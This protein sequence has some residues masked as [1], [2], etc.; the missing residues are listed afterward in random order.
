MKNKTI[1]LPTIILTI[2]FTALFF[3]RTSPQL[4]PNIIHAQSAYTCGGSGNV[5]SVFSGG[6]I[7][8]A[9]NKAKSGDTIKLSSGTYNTTRLKS[10]TDNITICS[11]TKHAAVI[12]NDAFSESILIDSDNVTIRGITFTSK[13]SR[14]AGGSV[15]MIRFD[16]SSGGIIEDNIIEKAST[17]QISVGGS[18]PG[19]RINNVT[20]RNNHL[21]DS[22]L[23]K[24]EGE[25][26]YIGSVQD[27]QVGTV[28]NVKIYGNTIENFT[29]NAIDIKEVGTNIDIYNNI[30]RNHL[31]TEA[32]QHQV[33]GTI[34]M[35]GRDIK[36][37]DNIILDAKNASSWGIFAIAPNAN[38]KV[39][40][41]VVN[42]SGPNASSLISVRSRSHN[43][44]T[45]SVYNNVF[46]NLSS[47]KVESSSGLS[48]SN[49]TGLPNGAQNSACDAKEGQTKAKM[50]NT[51]EP[52]KKAPAPTA[53]PPYIVIP[54]L[55]CLGS[56]PKP[57]ATATIIPKKYENSGG[58]GHTNNQ[59]TSPQTNSTT[60]PTQKSAQ[61]TTNEDDTL[62]GSFLNS[63]RQ[64]F[65]TILN[66]LSSLLN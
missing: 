6:S 59:K 31:Q 9:L 22:G 60:K 51:S 58:T 44:G 24:N 5:I 21:R 30:F 27:S 8:A 4:S 49:N 43:S 45:S 19:A 57:D 40:D 41:N 32:S 3:L 54:T 66:F 10:G 35:S 15:G 25:A 64:L 28:S 62:F 18:K 20:I 14:G 16:S 46:C 2:F 17:S 61:T 39:Y 26:I 50:Q 33:G 52:T 53:T 36:F 63:L 47:Y 13:N 55:V 11:A 48:L 38:N 56:C 37:H 7:E 34:V 23:A 65:E 1:Y 42:R 12:N 29:A